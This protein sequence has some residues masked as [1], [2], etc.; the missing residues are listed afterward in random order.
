MVST[1]DANASTRRRK[2]KA[3]ERTRLNG[4][5]GDLTAFERFSL[6][7][8]ALAIK[9]HLFSHN[10]DEF[11]SQ[12]A[13]EEAKIVEIAE[14]ELAA[15][16]I[17]QEEVAKIEDALE[18]ALAADESG[19]QPTP[20]IEATPTEEAS[21]AEAEEP[22]AAEDISPADASTIALETDPTASNEAAA[23]EKPVL[24][25]IPES[26]PLSQA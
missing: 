9:H 20:M 3:T 2:R 24:P 22:L 23:T 1:T 5:E 18:E 10:S 7:T 16:I 13:T 12:F 8:H 25:I 21:P 4:G 14:E 19:M 6:E 15:E 17:A 11:F 26:E